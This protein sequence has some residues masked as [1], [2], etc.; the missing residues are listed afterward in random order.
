MKKIFNNQHEQLT[1]AQKIAAVEAFTDEICEVI[2]SMDYEDVEP[3]EI[4]AEVDFRIALIESVKGYCCDMVGN[5]DET[6]IGN[7]YQWYVL[8]QR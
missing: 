3:D 8:K 2:R 7:M 5:F 4:E 6:Q 1:E